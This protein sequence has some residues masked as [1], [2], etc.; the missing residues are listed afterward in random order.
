MNDHVATEDAARADEHGRLDARARIDL[1]PE[2]DPHAGLDLASRHVELDA[3]EQRVEVAEPVPVSYTHL[4]AHET[5]HDLVCRLLLDKK[6]K[7][8]GETRPAADW[9]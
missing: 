1:R 6:N 4:R 7:A 2:A 3:A 5:R 8:E 9:V